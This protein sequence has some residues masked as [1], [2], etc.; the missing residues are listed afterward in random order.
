MKFP[1]EEKQDLS[2]GGGHGEVNQGDSRP[3]RQQ[4]VHARSRLEEDRLDEV[5][6][7]AEEI[8]GTDGRQEGGVLDDHGKFIAE[9]RQ[10]QPQRLW[11]NDIEHGLGGAHSE[12]LS[13]LELTP[14]D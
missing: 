7:Y 4:P 6:A 14:R 5:L 10:A 11:Q 9:R 8:E 1:L 12:S 13:G 3:H 2:D